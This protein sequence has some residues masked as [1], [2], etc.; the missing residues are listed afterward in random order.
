VA[1]AEPRLI[2]LRRLAERVFFAPAHPLCL[3][4]CRVVLCAQ[5]LWILLSRPD[6]PLFARWPGEFLALVDPMLAWRFGAVLPVAVEA[7]LFLLLHAALV[8]ALLGLRSGPSC[9]LSALLLY[10]FAPFEEMVAGLPHTAFG[11]LTV[12][13]LGLFLLSFARQGPWRGEPSW[14]SRWP[15]ALIQLL[16]AFSYFFPTLAKLRFSGPGWY[17]ADTI[18]HY[19]LGNATVTGAPLALALA[20]RPLLCGA[21]AAFTLLLEASAPLVV[22]SSR[23]A[24]LFVP[25]ALLFHLAILLTI[26]YFFPSLP[27]LLLLLPWDEL[28]RRLDP[29]P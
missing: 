21:S 22:V 24:L 18:H 1:A 17:T 15:F 5:A 29:R 20:A 8:A 3:A 23:F 13:T 16:F 12:P 10:H 11:G 4:S 7:T 26:G 28:G 2:V 19:A 25:A 27:L 14:E 6:L 9:F